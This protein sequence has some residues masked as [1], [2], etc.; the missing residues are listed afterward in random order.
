MIVDFRKSTVPPPPPSVMDSPITSVESF[1]FLGTTI[2]QDLKWEP[3]ISSLIKKAQQR[4]YFLRQLRKAKLPAQM[5]VQFYTAIIESILTS[6]ITVWFAGATVRDKQRLQRIVRS[7]EEVIGRSLPSLQDLVPLTAQALLQHAPSGEK[8]RSGLRLRASATCSCRITESSTEAPLDLPL[9]TSFPSAER[10]HLLLPLRTGR[11]L[12]HTRTQCRWALTHDPLK[13]MKTEPSG[14]RTLR[15][16]SPHRNAYRAEFQA[17]KKAFDQPHKDGDA[18]PKEPRQPRGR[19]YGAHVSRIK[20]MF[21]QMGTE[22]PAAK[23]RGGEEVS[24]QKIAKPTNFVNKTDG[25]VVKLQHSSSSERIGAPGHKFSETRK[26]FEQQSRDQSQSPVFPSS[27][28]KRGSHEQLDDWRGPRSNRGSQDSLDSLCSRTDAA[29]P[30]V[31]QLSA[32][33]ENHSQAQSSYRSP[34]RRA[35]YSPDGLQRPGEVSEDDCRL[36]PVRGTYRSRTAGGKLPSSISAEEFRSLSPTVEAREVRANDYSRSPKDVPNANTNGT[37]LNGSYKKAQEDKSNKDLDEAKSPERSLPTTDPEPV[38]D[39]GGSAEG[40]E[41]EEDSRGPRVVYTADGDAC[42]QGWGES[43]TDAEDELYADDEHDFVYDP[44]AEVHQL[45]GLPPERLEEIPAKRKISFSTGPI[46]DD[47]ENALAVGQC[48]VLSGCELAKGLSAAPHR[49]TYLEH[50]AACWSGKTNVSRNKRHLLGFSHTEPGLEMFVIG[51]ERPG[52]QSEVASLIQQTLE[53]ERRQRELLE[54]QYAHY[55]ADDDETGEYATDDEDTPA[56]PGQKSIEV[57]ELPESEDVLSPD[58]LDANKLYQKF[59]QLQIKHTVTEAEIQ[60]LKNKL[61]SV[62]HEKQR[63]EK[64]KCQLKASIEENKERMLKLEAYW[65]EAQTLCHT[66]NEHLKEAQAQYQALDKKYSKAKKLIKDYQQKEVEL[67]QKEDSERRRL[68]DAE[69]AHL[70]EIQGLQVRICSLEAELVQLMQQNGLQLNNN[71]S[72]ACERR[73]SAP[74]GEME[75]SAAK[76]MCRGLGHQAGSA[77][78][79]ASEA[80]SFDE[81]PARG[82]GS[83]EGSPRSQAVPRGCRQQGSPLRSGPCGGAEQPRS[84]EASVEDSPGKLKAK[85]PS[86][87]KDLSSSSSVDVSGVVDGSRRGPSPLALSSDESLDMIDDEILDQQS[88]PQARSVADWSPEQVALWLMGLGLEHHIPQFTASNIQGEE[89]LQLDSTELKA[90][91]VSSSQDR[92]LIKRKIKE[93]KVLQEKMLCRPQ[94]HSRRRDT[95]HN[96]EE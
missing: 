81:V 53:Q 71:N 19:Q 27:R 67:L 79:E 42:F 83:R 82:P 22:N 68:E 48:A 60:K 17:L 87:S 47:G 2:T 23:T 28:D 38:S 64:E 45:P 56:V 90:L 15:S 34:G 18:K 54:Q 39:R 30:T 7:A 52:Q 51:R 21:M 49:L 43:C 50:R 62:E 72:N 73:A 8:E 41:E 59:K 12:C 11:I 35:L 63:W 40:P 10:V 24:P 5:L 31:S 58:D 25:S 1:R 29:S 37:Q 88:Q 9:H 6:S 57:F 16:A 4:M 93:L 44:G 86:L 95:E 85:D 84:S 92:V 66:V 55:D 69:K 33:F 77:E 78:G 13:M 96:E 76:N 46:T 94:E 3:T 61:S 80:G 74:P 65:I 89:L 70:A 14:E 26:L 75:V 32:V 20:D 91:G 36:S